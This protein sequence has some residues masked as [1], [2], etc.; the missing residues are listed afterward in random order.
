[1]YAI[2]PQAGIELGL[3]KDGSTEETLVKKLSLE[4][5]KE[6]IADYNRQQICCGLFSSD[7]FIASLK[8]L[9]EEIKKR[10]S[11]TAP[12]VLA[13]LLT[14]LY[15]PAVSGVANTIKDD[16]TNKTICKEQVIYLKVCETQYEDINRAPAYLINAIL[17]NDYSSQQVKEALGMKTFTTSTTILDSL[18]NEDAPLSGQ[19]STRNLEALENS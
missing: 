5:V 2:P 4:N 11:T 15:T 10:R 13:K 14:C 16:F 18:S 1:M 17:L 9:A 19:G 12:E 3:S 8:E 7:P 6:A